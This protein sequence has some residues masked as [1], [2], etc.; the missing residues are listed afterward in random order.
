MGI[1]SRL[2]RQSLQPPTAEKLPPPAPP[3]P[4]EEAPKDLKDLKKEIAFNELKARIHALMIH[5]LDLARLEEAPDNILMDDLRRGIEMILTEERMAL[6]LPEKD[7]LTKE[8]RDELLATVPW[9]R[10]SMIPASLTSW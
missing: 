5:L 3:P 1:M 10:C 7:R 4:R 6:P 8:I 9:S 2:Q